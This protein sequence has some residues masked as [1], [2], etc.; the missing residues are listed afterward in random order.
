MVIGFKTK[1]YADITGE[2]ITNYC[3]V[4][5]VVGKDGTILSTSFKDM[6][7]GE[8]IETAGVTEEN[9][10]KDSFE[11]KQGDN[12]FICKGAKVGDYVVVCGE[13]K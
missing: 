13:P 3:G 11:M 4:N 12:S 2:N 10:A 8:K 1:D 6:A 5:T 7:T 9:I